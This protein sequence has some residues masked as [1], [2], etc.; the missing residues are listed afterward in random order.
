MPWQ[1]ELKAKGPWLAL[2]ENLEGHRL[3]QADGRST[4]TPMATPMATI[5]VNFWN[6]NRLR[7]SGPQH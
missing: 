3:A 7:R 4:N 5:C 2:T 6:R 1:Q